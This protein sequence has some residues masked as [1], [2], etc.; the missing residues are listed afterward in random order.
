L[1]V[2]PSVHPAWNGSARLGE[3]GR[4]AGIDPLELE[5]AIE[6]ADVKQALRS[7]TDEAIALGVF[8]VP[9]VAV[10]AD[11]FWGDDRL[12]DAAQAYRADQCA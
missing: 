9:T 11:L 3:A 8:G 12:E 10:G 4:R 1:P 6:D 2:D 7:V 5:G